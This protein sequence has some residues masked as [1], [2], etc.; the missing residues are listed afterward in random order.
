VW[1]LVALYTPVLLDCRG[2]REEALTST[3][4]DYVLGIKR[5]HVAERSRIAHAGISLGALQLH[6]PSQGLVRPPL[7]TQ[8]ALPRLDIHSFNVR[9]GGW[10]MEEAGGCRREAIGV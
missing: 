6:G 10:R 4:D 5:G 1:T 9:D 7:Q 3:A 2:R 8:P